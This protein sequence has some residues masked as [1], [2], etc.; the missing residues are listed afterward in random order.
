MIMD[1]LGAQPNGQIIIRVAEESSSF[2][3]RLHITSEHQKKISLNIDN[4]Y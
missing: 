3:I 1:L 4:K 2:N